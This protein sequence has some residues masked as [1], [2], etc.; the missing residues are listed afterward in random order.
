MELRVWVKSYF[1]D[2][3]IIRKRRENKKRKT[4]NEI[5]VGSKEQSKKEIKEQIC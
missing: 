5:E 3:P 2:N 4:E 1:S